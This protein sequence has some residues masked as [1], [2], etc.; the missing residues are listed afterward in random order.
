MEMQIQ[1]APQVDCCE[2]IGLA[3]KNYSK[4]SG[5]SRRSEFWYY[6]IFFYG[7][8]LPFYYT[9]IKQLSTEYDYDRTNKDILYTALIILYGLC[10][11]FLIIPCFSLSVRRLHDTGKSGFFV[12]IYL[13][14]LVGPFILLFLCSVDSEQ[15]T[16]EYGP[17]PKYILPQNDP[18]NLNNSAYGVP[19]NPYS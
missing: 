17:S 6:Q 3:F 8:V 18:L 10:C 16:N 14:P 15:N 4:C 13:I 2:A 5:R 9:A 1:I 12:L 19:E 11:I 7:I